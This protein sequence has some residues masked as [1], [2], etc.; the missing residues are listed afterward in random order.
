MHDVGRFLFYVH[1]LA[2][3]VQLLAGKPGVASATL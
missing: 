1:P 3:K 2:A